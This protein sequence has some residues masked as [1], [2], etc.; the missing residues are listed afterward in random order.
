[1]IAGEDGRHHPEQ[2]SAARRHPGRR[3]LTAVRDAPGEMT[4]LALPVP[5]PVMAPA[6]I[7]TAVRRAVVRLRFTTEVHLQEGLARL[8][9]EV[10]GLKRAQ[11]VPIRDPRAELFEALTPATDRV[12]T[13]AAD[14][15][16][17]IGMRKGHRA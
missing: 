9:A 14:V 10:L 12:R 6:Q 7:V 1:M 8:L 2:A 4:P 3:T 11:S 17:R 15:L 16:R 5:A 13:L